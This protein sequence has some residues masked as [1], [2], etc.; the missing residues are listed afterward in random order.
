MRTV[1]S[2]WERERTQVIEV[3]LTYKPDQKKW[4]AGY[5]WI[6]DPG[7]LPDNRSYV[8]GALKATERRLKRSPEQ[9]KVYQKQIEDMIKRG[10]ARKLTQREMDEYNGPK[11]HISHHEVLKPESKSTPCRIV[12]NSSANFRGH[13]LNE[14]YAKGPDML[15]NLLG[16]LL[17]FRERAVAMVGDIGKMFHAIDIPLVDQMTHRFLWRGMD[18]EREPDTYAMTS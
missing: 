9:T 15:N 7:T 18:E 10:A 2:G 8:L 14:Y 1:S 17:R 16:V 13:I 12:F 3:N 6:K 5:P 11:F 4:E